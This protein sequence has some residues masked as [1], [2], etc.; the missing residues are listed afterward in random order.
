MAVSTR[1]RGPVHPPAPPPFI[2]PLALSPSFII[3]THIS[4]SVAQRPGIHPGSEKHRFTARCE[5]ELCSGH[6]PYTPAS[7]AAPAIIQKNG[8][9][10]RPRSSVPCAASF[11]CCVALM[12]A[13]LPFLFRLSPSLSLSS[14]GSPGWFCS[15]ERHTVPEKRALSLSLSC[16]LINSCL[17][18]SCWVK[19]VFHKNWTAA[20]MNLCFVRKL[21]SVALGARAQIRGSRDVSHRYSFCVR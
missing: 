17:R 19:D 11:P 3:L 6:G 1:R 8:K 18:N 13:P 12:S 16:L 20:V 4:R 21:F 7:T 15:D 5:G 2:S 10:R 9:W 14:P